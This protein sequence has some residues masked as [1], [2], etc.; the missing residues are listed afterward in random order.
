MVLNRHLAIF[1][2]A[3]VS[4]SVIK[5]SRLPMEPVMIE[6]PR[7]GWN[8]ERIV[9]PLGA[10]FTQAAGMCHRHGHQIFGLKMP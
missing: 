4:L 6:R 8:F 3:F 2:V 5:K 1:S 7:E 10:K 9:E